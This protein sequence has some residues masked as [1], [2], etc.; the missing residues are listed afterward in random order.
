[1][2]G[3]FFRMIVAVIVVVVLFVAL[4][5]LFRLLGFPL[6]ADAWLIIRLSM[7]AIALFYIAFGRAQPP[8]V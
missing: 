5:A 7:A 6:T 3:I 1:M 2:S 8:G 4:P